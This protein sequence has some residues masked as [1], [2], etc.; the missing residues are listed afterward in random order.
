MSQWEPFLFKPQLWETACL[1]S[2]HQMYSLPLSDFMSLQEYI[3]IKIATK[4]PGVWRCSLSVSHLFPQLLL[5]FWECPPP[6]WKRRTS[7]PNRP[8]QWANLRSGLSLP[9]SLSVSIPFSSSLLSCSLAHGLLLRILCAC[10][11]LPPEEWLGFCC[12]C[13]L[14]SAPGP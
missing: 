12:L 6:Y 2:D 4:S 10:Q 3:V 7:L 13:V 9:G 5:G 14:D 11:L 1:T 8:S